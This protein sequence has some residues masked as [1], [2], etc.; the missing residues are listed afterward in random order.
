MTAL[1]LILIIL[2]LLVVLFQLRIGAEVEYGEAGIRVT[3]KLAGRPVLLFPRPE[4][5]RT[6]KE[7]EAEKARRKAAKKEKKAAKKAE[8]QRRKAA[9]QPPKPQP[10]EQPKKK[11][12]TVELV[13]ALLPVVVQ[14]LGALKK[15]IRI[16]P[17]TVHYTA[18]CVDAADTA[19]LYGRSSGAAGIVVALLEENFDVRR[20][21][22]TVDL[23][24]LAGRSV[25]YVNAGISIKVGQVLYLAVRYGL[26]CLKVFLQKRKSSGKKA[27][28]KGNQTGAD[29]A[30]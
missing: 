4:K 24:F 18:G 10:E 16:D 3:A 15:R 28:P 29:A 8:K 1:I 6:Q 9:K 20:R 17:L 26:A 23:D 22:V 12:G 5:T 30:K 11:G 27:A 13:L 14:A 2:V 21:D 7:K 25:I 19:L